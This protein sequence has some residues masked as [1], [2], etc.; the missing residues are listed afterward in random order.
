MNVFL[1]AVK[2]QSPFY[3]LK[4]LVLIYG[5]LKEVVLIWSLSRKV[6]GNLLI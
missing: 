6:G 4:K 5:S 1:G 2:K 3:A